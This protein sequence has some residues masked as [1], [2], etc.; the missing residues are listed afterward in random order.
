MKRR[1][2][3]LAMVL[4]IALSLLPTAALATEEENAENN[5]NLAGMSKQDDTSDT[6]IPATT[7]PIPTDETMPEADGTPSAAASFKI[8]EDTTVLES[9]TYTLENNVTVSGALTVPSG[10]TVTID[11]GG[12]TLTLRGSER[13]EDVAYQTKT[14]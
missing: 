9:G 5:D 13:I 8:T 3:S 4:A 10:E 12:Y 1:L 14:A 11:L 2:L 6:E 7:A